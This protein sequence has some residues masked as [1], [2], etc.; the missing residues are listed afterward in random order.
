MNS[1]V[2]HNQPPSQIDF[3][4]ETSEELSRWLSENPVVETEEQA[5]SGKLL[6]DRASNC[7]KDLEAERRG[8]CIPLET[9]VREIND[10]YRGPRE[11]LQKISDEL[12]WR[13]TAFIKAEEARREQIYLEKQQAALLAEERA[14]DA[15]RREQ[16]AKEEAATG[17][18]DI[19]IHAATVEADRAFEAFTRSDRDAARAERETRVKLGGGFNRALSLRARETLIVDDPVAAVTVMGWNDDMIGAIIKAAKAYRKLTG[20]LPRGVRSE[21]DRTL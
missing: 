5:R 16:E 1:L 4:Q 6:V 12:E 20:D 14:R 7:I 15:E 3:T 21:K 2:G 11:T 8:K 18:L 19:D 10:T 9:Q 17:V 13:L